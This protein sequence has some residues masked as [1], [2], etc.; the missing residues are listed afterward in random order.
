VTSRV[1]LSCVF[2]RTLD[3]VIVI[4]VFTIGPLQPCPPP[5]N[6]GKISRM[7][8]NAT[9]MRHF[10]PKISTIFWGGG[11]ANSPDPTPTGEGNTPDQTPHLS[12]CSPRPP[13]IFFPISIITL[14]SDAAIDEF[15]KSNRRLSFVSRPRPIKWNAF[16]S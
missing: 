7:A 6:C 5:L 1:D 4:G 16:I 12:A 15:G 11:K 8:K 3:D 2:G 10:Q 14:D 9:K 13:P